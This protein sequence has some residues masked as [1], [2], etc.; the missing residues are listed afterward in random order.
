MNTM[1]VQSAQRRIRMACLLKNSIH[2]ISP[3][4]FPERTARPLDISVST[5]MTSHSSFHASM[6][7]RHH[8]KSRVQVRFSFIHVKGEFRTITPIDHFLPYM[9][10][11]LQPNRFIFASNSDILSL[12]FTRSE[13]TFLAT[14]SSNFSMSS[15]LFFAQ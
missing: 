14:E 8:E 13:Y 12:R 7:P 10:S 6:I 4:P 11:I 2:L 9:E 3:S 15:T 1:G 5:C